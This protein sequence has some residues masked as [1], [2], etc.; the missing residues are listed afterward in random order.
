MGEAPGVAAG[1]QKMLE[2]D[3]KDVEAVGSFLPGKVLGRTAALL[4]L[5]VLVLGLA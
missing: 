5:G 1:T 3:K 2:L 4:A